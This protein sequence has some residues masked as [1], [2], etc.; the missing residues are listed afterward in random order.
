MFIMC[1]YAS[2]SP[3]QMSYCLELIIQYKESI[4]NV[5]NSNLVCESKKVK[6]RGPKVLAGTA[7]PSFW[8]R[9]TAKDWIS[10]KLPGEVCT[11]PFLHSCPHPTGCLIDSFPSVFFSVFLTLNQA[12]MEV[13]D[14][15]RQG[16]AFFLLIL[17]KSKLFNLL[18][19]RPKVSLTK[20]FDETIK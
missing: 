6:R 13:A 14:C 5:W 1:L 9:A 17:M 20:S 4:I 11:H 19:P 7:A 3:E 15:P 16:S 2:G 10:W 8:L 12:S 18:L